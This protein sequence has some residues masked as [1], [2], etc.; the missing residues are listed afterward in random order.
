MARILTDDEDDLMPPPDS[1]KQLD[2]R[3][4]AL[5]QQWITEAEYDLHWAYKPVK[6]VAPPKAEDE[7]FVINDVDRFVLRGIEAAGL[8]PSK[9][10]DRVTLARRLYY[11]LLGMPPLPWE[12]ES[13]VKDRSAGA[14]EKF[15]EQLLNDPRYGERMAAH[16]LDLVRYADTIGYHSDAVREVSAYRDYV[17]DAFNKNKPYDEFTIE[18]LAGDLL[19]EPSITQRMHRGTIACCK[20]RRAVRRRRSIARST[21]PT[22]C[23]TSPVCGWVRRLAVRSVTTTNM[24]RSRRAT[25]T[26][27][28]PSSRTS[29]RRWGGR[30]RISRS[31]PSRRT[32]RWT[33]CEADAG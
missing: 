22:V 30:T 5:L 18:Q 26:A 9:Q 11:D 12:I 13:F 14:Y 27:W 6:R 4:K 29:R 1:G 17:I 10:A 7:S 16:W 8:K 33:R 25:F 28:R 19:P 23:A 15:V 3:Q 21:R 31:R 24:T 32:V 20:R 2:E